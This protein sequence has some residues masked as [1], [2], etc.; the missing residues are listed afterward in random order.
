MAPGKH[1]REES[2]VFGEQ[3]VGCLEGWLVLGL[4]R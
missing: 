3:R 4:K 2:S 1:S